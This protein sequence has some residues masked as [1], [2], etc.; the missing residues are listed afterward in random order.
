MLFAV[1]EKQITNT[2]LCISFLLASRTGV[3]G[4]TVALFDR[5]PEAIPCDPV[6]K[7]HFASLTPGS[8]GWTAPSEALLQVPLT[9]PPRVVTPVGPIP[10]RGKRGRRRRYTH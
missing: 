6:R 10:V 8:L 3:L 1:A 9:R 2:L 5:P 4:Q 7:G